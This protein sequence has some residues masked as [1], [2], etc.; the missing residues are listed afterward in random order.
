MRASK[1]IKSYSSCGFTLIELL[2][3]VA[4]IAILAAL[5]LPALSRAKGLGHLDKCK[6]NERQMGLGMAMY[7]GDTRFYPPQGLS[8]ETLPH[9]WFQM[10]EPYT[11]NKWTD[12]LYDCPGLRLDRRLPTPQTITRM[13]N[14]IIGEYGYNWMGTGQGGPPNLAA[15]ALGLGPKLVFA[16]PHSSLGYPTPIL[17]SEV[18]VP[19]NMIALGDSY[20]ETHVN[21]FDFGLTIMWGYQMPPGNVSI[22]QRA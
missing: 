7:V 18:L 1:Q 11:A 13:H 4:I 6:S 20:D 5:L 17:E 15:G 10:L 16:S 19:S 9:Y 22:K 3:V 8:D 14:N 12:A 21:I 2:V